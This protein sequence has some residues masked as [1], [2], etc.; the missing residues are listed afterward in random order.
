MSFPSEL[1]RPRYLSTVVNDP[2]MNVPGLITSMFFSTTVTSTSD[3]IDIREDIGKGG[4]SKLIQSVHAAH[5]VGGGTAKVRSYKLPVIR[6]KKIIKS[7][8][9]NALSVPGSVYPSGKN[10]NDEMKRYVLNE[11]RNLNDRFHLRMEDFA[12]N[13]AQ[14]GITYTDQEQGVNFEI[15][16]GFDSAYTPTLTSA[17]AWDNKDSNGNSTADIVADIRSYSSLLR[18]S[19]GAGAAV[20][21][22]GAD[23][24]SAF[25]DNTVVQKKLDTNNF[26]TGQLVVGENTYLGRFANVDFY[27]Y[28]DYYRAD[29]GSVSQIFPAD[30]AIFFPN[31]AV[32]GGARYFGPVDEEEQRFMGGIFAKQYEINDPSG[33]VFL[34]EAHALPIPKYLNSTVV[35][36]VV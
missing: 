9:L 10:R 20:C 21:I 32:Y 30:K 17:A 6:E 29:D 18:K 27:E 19:T 33:R 8:D 35:A 22:L 26:R 2:H 28:A 31:R 23:A 34:I 25:L 1:L 5:A 12:I 3:T 11:V 7:S 15:D 16:L 24:A 36:T 4:M 13:M 14:G